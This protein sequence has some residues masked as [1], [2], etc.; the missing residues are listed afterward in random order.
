M[1]LAFASRER[2]RNVL[3][4]IPSPGGPRCHHRPR[5]A[6]ADDDHQE[7]PGPGLNDLLTLGIP[8][9]GG[10]S[11]ITWALASRPYC[12]AL[13][14]TVDWVIPRY[15]AARACV[16]YRVSASRSS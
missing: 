7:S 13:R 4:R 16:L 8:L 10:S 15:F 11:A 3:P 6:A 14:A 5:R 9:V 2:N 1:A 12:L